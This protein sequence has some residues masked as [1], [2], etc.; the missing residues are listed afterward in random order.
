MPGRGKV[1]RRAPHGG[2]FNHQIRRTKI[3][4]LMLSEDKADIV[5]IQ[6]LDGRR[7]NLF[8]PQIGHRDPGAGFGEEF[9]AGQTSPVKP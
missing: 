3:L 2:I 8:V 1:G 6:G 4:Q 7:E 9:G 5:A